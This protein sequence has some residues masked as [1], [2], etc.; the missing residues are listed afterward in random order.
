[1]NVEVIMPQMGESITEGKILKWLKKEGERIEKDETLLEISTDKVDT[2]VP[3]PAA[4]VVTKIVIPELETVAVKTVLAII[5]TETL[6]GTVE[7]VAQPSVESVKH[8]P[9][10]MT[11]ETATMVE[12]STE[13]P[14]EVSRIG[15]DGKGKRFYSPLVRNI[16]K[17]ESV[18]AE[19]LETI[20]GTGA[21]G[22]ATKRDILNYVEHRRTQI[23]GKPKMV[24]EE[25]R[26]AEQ[27]ESI[28]TGDVEIIQMDNMRQKIAEH[29]VRS[30][31]TAAHV[32][33]VSECDM[34]RIAQYRNKMKDAFEKREGF[35]LTF[36]PFIVEAA[37]KAL[38][39]FPLVNSSIEGTKIIR[40]KF[41]NI[42]VAVALDNGGLIVPVIRHADEKNL[43][44][45]ARAVNDLATRARTKKLT[46]DDVQNGTFSITN[47][48]IFGN[49]FGTPIINQPQVAILGIGA[50]KKRP[51][52][53][54]NDGVD[55]I[56]IRSMMFLSLSYDHR[57]VDGALGGMFLQRVVQYLENFDMNTAI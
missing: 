15:G 55:S 36:T 17:A 34:T 32:T 22:R 42:G 51:V 12:T 29:M 46:P 26:S 48:G 18:S 8:V 33:S 30:V 21:E 6:P 37:V 54:E 3:S 23:I 40:K 13:T 43:V 16:A 47:P 53:I 5:D 56:A 52:V 7:T 14:S 4:G 10:E 28:S 44:G 38:K 27:I 2:E 19:E 50:I 1:M 41:I 35:K 24:V 9:A 20:V 45:L 57:L 39:D 25:V 31:H 49:L 11:A